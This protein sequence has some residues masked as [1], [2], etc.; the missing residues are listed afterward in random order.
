[1]HE[2][3]GHLQASQGQLT[4]KERELNQLREKL[5]SALLDAVRV[6][7]AAPQ[8]AAATAAAARQG[9]RGA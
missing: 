8:S 7:G 2:L 9:M 5:R 1:V 6:V 4:V 3:S